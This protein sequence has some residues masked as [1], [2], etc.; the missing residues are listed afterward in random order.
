MAL[1]FIDVVIGFLHLDCNDRPMYGCTFLGAQYH[2]HFI[3]A[4]LGG[5]LKNEINMISVDFL[6]QW[7]F[8]PISSWQCQIT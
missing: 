2:Q 6:F 3:R 8:A 1:C 4:H 5:F 7:I